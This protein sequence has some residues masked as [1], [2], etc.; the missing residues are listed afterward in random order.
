MTDQLVLDKQPETLVGAMATIVRD[1][2][3]GGLAQLP[4]AGWLGA[5]IDAARLDPC[6]RAALEA[7]HARL[8]A[9][10]G[11]MLDAFGARLGVW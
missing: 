11:S 9:D 1:L 4:S 10:G 3:S 2:L 8:L 6:A 5:R 7:L